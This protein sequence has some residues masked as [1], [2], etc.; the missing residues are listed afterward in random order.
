MYSGEH[1]SDA[2]KDARNTNKKAVDDDDEKKDLIGRKIDLIIKGS[3][4]E[5]SSSEWKKSNSTTNL[6]QQQRI[7]NIRTNSAMLNK[8]SELAGVENL[9]L[10]GMDWVGKF[11]VEFIALYLSQTK[12]VRIGYVGSMIC[13]SEVCDIHCAHIIGDLVLP[14]KVNVLDMFKKTLNL[15]CILKQHSLNLLDIVTPALEKR[16]IE[17][18]LKLMDSVYDGPTV[19]SAPKTFFTPTKKRDRKN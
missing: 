18:Q 17:E 11:H 9:F 2:T 10:L 4:V 7:K 14:F 6:I 8:I 16:E 12:L 1:S 5:V 13:L 19:R 15:L 3:E